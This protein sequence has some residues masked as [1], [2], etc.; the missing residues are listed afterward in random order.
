MTIPPKV[1]TQNTFNNA[2][3]VVMD[4]TPSTVGTSPRHSFSSSQDAGEFLPT[5]ERAMALSLYLDPSVD[6]SSEFDAS[7]ELSST[8]SS[9]SIDSSHDS[10]VSS[11]STHLKT[12]LLKHIRDI[13]AETS[14][15]DS[16]DVSFLAARIEGLLDARIDSLLAENARLAGMIQNQA[17]TG[18]AQRLGSRASFRADSTS[19]RF[20][21]STSSFTTD[22]PDLDTDDGGVA[23]S[24]THH[25][26]SRSRHASISAGM[27][28]P[29]TNKPHNHHTR[30]SSSLLHDLTSSDPTPGYTNTSGDTPI[31]DPGFVS[32]TRSGG[33]GAPDPESQDPNE[34]SGIRK[35][36][37]M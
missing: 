15:P 13:V 24:T 18:H 34:A 25:T 37:G 2:V 12:V 29:I 6:V 27:L 7:S 35:G 28:A 4:S 16:D 5:L 19:T 23:L 21:P 30:S 9:L 1:P 8:R 33:N 36:Q 11:L 14:E 3:P 31:S 26:L 22:D 32:D 20:L 10:D 17:G